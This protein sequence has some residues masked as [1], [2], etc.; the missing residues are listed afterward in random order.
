[1]AS[2]SCADSNGASLCCLAGSIGAATY[3]DCD[4]LA[5]GYTTCTD[6][7]VSQ[8]PYTCDMEAWAD[9]FAANVLGETC[10][11]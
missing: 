10:A 1:M 8:A 4:T 5:A 7:L 2:M 6:L 11:Q 9:G 3:A